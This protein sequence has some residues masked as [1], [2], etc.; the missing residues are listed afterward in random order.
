MSSTRSTI[1]SET[2]GRGHQIPA[3][4]SSLYSPKPRTATRSETIGTFHRSLNLWQ[5][6]LAPVLGSCA[7]EFRQIVRAEAVAAGLHD[8]H[9]GR[10]RWCVPGHERAR[11]G[12]LTGNWRQTPI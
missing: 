9:N 7:V 6:A 3:L 8:G 2:A 11:T 10:E 12:W 4:A 5:V 1:A